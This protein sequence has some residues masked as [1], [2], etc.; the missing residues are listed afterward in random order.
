M[1]TKRHI[2]RAQLKSKF[3]YFGMERPVTGAMFGRAGTPEGHEG[4]NGA[5]SEPGA[6]NGQDPVGSGNA[7]IRPSRKIRINV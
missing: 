2:Q 3:L 1:R 4:P 7:A 5:I 6:R